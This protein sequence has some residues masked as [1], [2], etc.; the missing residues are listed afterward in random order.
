MPEKGEVY[1][2]DGVFARFDGYRIWLWTNGRKA[3]PIGC[4]PGV[5]DGLIRMAR[6]AWGTSQPASEKSAEK[7]RGQARK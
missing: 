3:H 5:M 7:S 1:L 4:D 2:G 6:E